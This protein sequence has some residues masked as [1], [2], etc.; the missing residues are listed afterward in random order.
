M[1]GGGKKYTGNK[2][3]WHSGKIQLQAKKVDTA[4]PCRQEEATSWGNKEPQFLG[5]S[6]HPMDTAQPATCQARHFLQCHLECATHYINSS[7]QCLFIFF[8]HCLY[9]SMEFKY[10]EVRNITHILFTSVFM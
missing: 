6:G 4:L 8:S 2:C 10:H 7:C 5:S 9:P 3:H 1:F